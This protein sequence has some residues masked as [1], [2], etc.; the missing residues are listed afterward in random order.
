[1]SDS[2]IAVKLTGVSKRFGAVRAL[3]DINLSLQAGQIHAL[4]GQNGAGKST[5]LGLISGRIGTSDGAVEVNGEELGR[6]VT[7]VSARQAGVA[8]IYQELTVV[9]AMTAID[10]VF[11]GCMTARAGFVSRR[12]QR[13]RFAELSGRLNVDIDPGARADALSPANQQMLQVMRAL[14][15]EA[16]VLLLD[17]PTAALSQVERE[18][19]FAV[20]RDLRA[21]GITL[22]FV[23]HFLDEVLDVSETVTVFRDGRLVASEPVDDWTKP[24]L[25]RAMLGSELEALQ[26]AA[27]AHGQHAS[28]PAAGASPAALARAG[29]PGQEVLR[30]EGLSSRDGVAAVDLEVRAGEIVGLG[31]LVGSGRTSLLNALSGNAYGLSGRMWLEGRE[32]PL[33]ST[34]RRAVDFG[35]CPVPEERKSAGIFAALPARENVMIG[36][37]SRCSRFGWVSRSRL[38]QRSEELAGQFGLPSPMLDQPAGQLSGGNQQKLLLARW[39]NRVPR[40]LLA[41]EATRGIDVGAK[42]TILATLRHLADSGAGVIFVSSELEEVVAASDRVYVLRAGRIVAHLDG[43]SPITEGTILNH[44]FAVREDVHV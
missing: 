28:R 39:G 16:R 35:I 42:G 30:V 14:T 24:K 4:V 5:C 9:P 43:S 12:P 40:V 15:L 17:E 41:D 37:L 34:A 32:V 25:I 13:R 11:L 22:V 29:G 2:Q 36:D 7:P 6:S 27:A 8:A 38:R 33:P 19:L 23:S 26:N 20:M 44:V 21:Q 18:S 3:T 31:G 10:N 1:M